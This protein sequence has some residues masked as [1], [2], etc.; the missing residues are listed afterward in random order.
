MIFMNIISLYMISN[1]VTGLMFSTTLNHKTMPIYMIN[2]LKQNTNMGVNSLQEKDVSWERT[3]NHNNIINKYFKNMNIKNYDNENNNFYGEIFKIYGYPATMI[4]INDNLN[5]KYVEEFIINK[6]LML[7]FDAAP[8]M[9]KLFYK[10]FKKINIKH[11][12]NKN[13]FLII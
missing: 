2:T 9:R 6:N 5:T 11:A 10:K 13:I 8:I 3:Y 4:I 12:L 7:M 1:I